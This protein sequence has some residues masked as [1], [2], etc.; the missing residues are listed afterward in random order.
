[1]SAFSFDG[2]GLTAFCKELEKIPKMLQQ[3]E[4]MTLNNAAFLFKERA[5]AAI[6]ENFTSRKP[7]FVNSSFRVTKATVQNLEAAAGSVA[8][9]SSTGFV[10][11]LTGADNRRRLP[12]M[13]ARGNNTAAII[14]KKNRLSPDQDFPEITD[15]VPMALS[16][17]AKTGAKGFII[18]EGEGW[19]PGLY[20][21]TAPKKTG[22]GST[23]KERLP[24]KQVQRFGKPQKAPRKFDW[25]TAALSAVTEG[26][27]AEA[28]RKNIDA[29]FKK[30]VFR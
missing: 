27:I 15:S 4:A 20:Q 28:Y 2:S 8:L 9:N 1:M 29:I 19:S 23:M 6:I 5:A 25:I 21:F 26:F 22:R 13:F 18:R 16:M 10:E 3:A 11:M 24:V 17:L 7:Q 12:T 30:K 14:P